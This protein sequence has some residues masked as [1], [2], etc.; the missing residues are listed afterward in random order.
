[1]PALRAL[2]LEPRADADL[3]WRLNLRWVAAEDARGGLAEVRVQRAER[4]LREVVIV[5]HGLRIE[6][7]E[8]VGQQDDP[9]R[10]G[11]GAR[12]RHGR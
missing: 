7:V 4:A 1:M 10:A 3:P 11:S 8:D 2:E 12:S 5:E 9:L 6:Q